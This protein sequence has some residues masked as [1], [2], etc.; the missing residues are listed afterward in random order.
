MCR[1]FWT[2]LLV[3]LFASA[4]FITGY[5]HQ[6]LKADMQYDCVVIGSIENALNEFRRWVTGILTATR[7]TG[8]ILYRQTKGT[9]S[10]LA[11]NTSQPGTMLEK[12]IFQKPETY[13]TSVMRIKDASRPQYFVPVSVWLP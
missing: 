13:A 7:R 11:N 10:L 6:A 4:F 8:P 5:V 9:F 3:Q 1:F 12:I 2:T